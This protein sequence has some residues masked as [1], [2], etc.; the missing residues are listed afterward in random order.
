VPEIGRCR[1]LAP[2]GTG[3]RSKSRQSLARGPARKKPRVHLPPVT[4]AQRR[5]APT[6][7]LSRRPFSISR[8]AG[9]GPPKSLASSRKQ[10]EG[11]WRFHPRGTLSNNCRRGTKSKKLARIRSGGGEAWQATEDRT[12]FFG[13]PMTKTA[14]ARK[15]SPFDEIPAA[16]GRITVAVGSR[17]EAGTVSG[18]P[19]SRS[20][21]GGA[22]MEPHRE[23][24]DC[25]PCYYHRRCNAWHRQL[26][27]VTPTMPSL[28]QGW[29]S[30]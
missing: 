12:P 27:L 16:P 3:C 20:V 23:Y 30:L 19:R 17:H 18:P 14:T 25:T 4:S 11:P 21:P 2:T 8:R 10:Q 28:P 9:L 7:S 1:N 29:V 22:D 15:P 6:R 24:G 5:P 13:S 26:P